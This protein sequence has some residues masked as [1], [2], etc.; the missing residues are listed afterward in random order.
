M[1]V[2]NYSNYSHQSH[3]LYSPLKS[4]ILMSF[5][6]VLRLLDL[7]KCGLSYYMFR[8]ILLDSFP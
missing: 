7:D 2:Y 8:N 4:S 1:H 5:C 6:L 3:N